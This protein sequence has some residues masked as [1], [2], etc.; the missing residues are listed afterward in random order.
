MD[1]TEYVT[2]NSEKVRIF[3][4]KITDSTNQRAREYAEEPGAYLPSVFV[5]EGQSA[6]RGRMGRHFDSERGAGIYMTFLFRP[7]DISDVGRITAD[8]AVKVCRA[9][10]RVAPVSLDI[11]WVNDVYVGGKKLAG[12][13]T[14]A[15]FGAEYGLAEYVAV[16]VGINLKSRKFPDGLDKIATTLEDASGVAVSA[17][18]LIYPLIEEF[19]SRGEPSE[20]IAEYRR[21]S[22]AVGKRVLVSEHSGASYYADAVGITDG[23]GLLLSRDGEVRELFS[24]E[25]SI[26][27]EV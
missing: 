8:T 6:G 4:Y 5:S 20:F 11:K 26:K 2:Q 12:I 7:T 10:E 19:F 13:L 1:H 24:G 18:D 27:F 21:R 15:K 17:D 3:R 9:I 22:I 25:I 14:E 23:A 16:G